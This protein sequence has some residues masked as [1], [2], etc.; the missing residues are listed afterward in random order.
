MAHDESSNI[1][2]PQ[3]SSEPPDRIAALRDRITAGVDPPLTKQEI[4]SLRAWHATL[5]KFHASV[6][7][8]ITSGFQVKMREIFV[9]SASK[10]KHGSFRQ[11]LGPRQW[12][13]CAAQHKYGHD[14][15][16]MPADITAQELTNIV[17][18]YLDRR[19]FAPDKKPKPVARRTVQLWLESRR[20]DK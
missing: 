9:I 15:A 12:I 8:N 2:G 20:Q 3:P 4:E 16:R 18:Q 10:T 1:V 7:M 6:S 13:E 17:N 5:L 19:S 11:N 14:L